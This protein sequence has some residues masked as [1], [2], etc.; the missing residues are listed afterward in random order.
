MSGSVERARA[1]LSSRLLCRRAEIEQ[2]TLNRV[3]SI[4][5]PTIASDPAYLDGLRT[6]VS[7][8]LDY[9]LAAIEQ[10]EERAPPV[11]PA[12]LAQARVAAR[13]GVSL[14]TMLR[15]YLAGY[16][17]LGDF[18]VDEAQHDRLTRGA[19]LRRLL[20]GQAVIFDRLLAIVS[21]EYGREAETLL[22]SS[23]WRQ[24]ERVERLLAGEL[25]EMSEL[26]YD[27]DAQHLG[28]VATGPGAGD[29]VRGLAGAVDCRLL[30]VPRSEERVWAWLGSRRR[31]ELD[32][33]KQIVPA[34]APAEA[35]LAIGEPGKGLAGWRL[36][37]RQ[38]CAAL[39]VALR[40]SERVVRYGDVA[41][42]ASTLKDDLLAS[43]LRQLYLAPLERDRDG[44]TA[45]RK[46][47]RAYFAADRNSASAASALGVTRQTVNNRLRAVEELLGRPL[48]A[49]ANELLT[50]LRLEE[51]ART[52]VTQSSSS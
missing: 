14:E 38:A 31:L 47:L 5:D 2:A 3:Y 44:G 20:R 46:T 32:D 34:T 15:R 18:L 25:L 28:L 19:T 49:C 16:T 30:L 50:A 8:A 27:F 11:P 21:E 42:L 35:A 13:N 52:G 48:N 26:K 24:A 9:G 41:L 4:S 36:T 37:H 33:L 10:G 45:A 12:L 6:A 17:L 23:E 43:S 7:A 29:T 51:L 22:E 1:G 39:P 40:S